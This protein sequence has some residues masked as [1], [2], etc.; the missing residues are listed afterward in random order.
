[1]GDLKQALYWQKKTREVMDSVQA[2][3]GR[4]QMSEFDAELNAPEPRT[5][6][7]HRQYIA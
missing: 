5:R 3:E 6:L 4:A 2:S 7:G 1:M